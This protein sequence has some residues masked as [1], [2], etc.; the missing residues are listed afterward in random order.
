MA[1]GKQ[2]SINAIESYIQKC[3]G[4][5]STWYVG[6]AADARNRLFNDHGVREEGDCWIY[7]QVTS[8]EVA[9]E[10][11]RHF[12]YAR[13]TDGG[14]GGGDETTDMVYAYRKSAHSNP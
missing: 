13:N 11:E 4:E 1:A 5:Y 3:G 12:V 6:I 10:V 14:P 9:R 8:S 2:D 7:N